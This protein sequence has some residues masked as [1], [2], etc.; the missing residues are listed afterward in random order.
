MRGCARCRRSE[1]EEEEEEGHETHG[2]A[3]SSSSSATLLAQPIL[4]A[5][6]AG[7][8]CLMK[9]QKSRGFLLASPAND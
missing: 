4:L 5:A 1:G 6:Q 8:R 3:I 2:R 9:P 7:G